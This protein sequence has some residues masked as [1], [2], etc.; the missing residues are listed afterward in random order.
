MTTLSEDTDSTHWWEH[1]CARTDVAIGELVDGF[2]EIADQ[3]I[4]YAWLPGRAR[5]FYGADFTTWSDLASETID[6]LVNRPKGG[7]GTVRA[8]VIAAREA[9][10][11]ARAT[12]DDEPLDAATT[13][14]RLLDRLTA[15][16][17]G[18]LSARVWALNPLTIPAT[19]H[20]LGATQVN[21]QRSTPRAYRRLQDLLADPAHAAVSDYAEQLRQRLGPLTREHAAGRTLR[22]L[23]LVRRVCGVPA[24]VFQNIA[25]DDRRG[26]AI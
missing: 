23:G 2:T 8:I 10:A 26:G 24:R 15:Y 16:D 21:V 19:A 6:T 18:L 22:D 20:K 7:I 4:P 1:I 17:H 13:I 14:S 3:A 5:T 25:L 11:T 12:R 9:V